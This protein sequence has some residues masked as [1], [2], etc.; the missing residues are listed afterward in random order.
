MNSEECSITEDSSSRLERGQRDNGTS[1]S[2]QKHHEGSI[3]VPIPWAVLAVVIIT[4]LSITIIALQVGKYNCPSLYN[5]LESSEHHVAS[6]EDDWVSY[7]RKCYFFSSTTRSWPSAQNSCSKD[8]ATLAVIDSKK[9]MV[10][11][12]RYAGGL[13]HW[14]GLKN[15]ANQTWKWANGKEFNSWFNLTGSEG[16]A[17]LNNTDVAAVDCAANLHWVCSKSSR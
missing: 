7:Q 10:F 1:M 4:S 16:C 5:N 11:L 3:Q 15:E 17:S 12:K 2:F 9:D 13:E 6:C 14:I 8:G